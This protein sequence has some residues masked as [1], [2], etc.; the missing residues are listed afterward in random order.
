MNKTK[1]GS[2]GILHRLIIIGGTAGVAMLS[3]RVAR[4][5]VSGLAVGLKRSKAKGEDT[6]RS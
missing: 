2:P 4:L 1:T 3:F 5:F 6:S